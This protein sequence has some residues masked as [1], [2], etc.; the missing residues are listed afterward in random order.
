MCTSKSSVP[1]STDVTDRNSSRTENPVEPFVVDNHEDEKMEGP[2]ALES[3]PVG[4]VSD[5]D[6]SRLCL[7]VTLEGATGGGAATE[8]A[9]WRRPGLPGAAEVR[10]V[11]W[12][13]MLDC[14]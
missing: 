5:P 13:E 7:S 3:P 11:T 10:D 9:E 6:L 2:N 4:S 12:E 1:E 14:L 8:V